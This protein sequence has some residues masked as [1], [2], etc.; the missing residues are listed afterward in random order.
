MTDVSVVT[1]VIKQ[2]LK[3]LP[4]SIIP[5][6]IY[7]RILNVNRNFY[8]ILFYFIFYFY[9]EINEKLID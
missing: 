8:L 9:F 2:Y 7:E 3:D 6:S 1:S 5:Q 4:T